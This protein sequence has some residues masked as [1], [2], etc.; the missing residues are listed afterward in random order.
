[1]LLR[2]DELIEQHLYLV[3]PIAQRV[4][5]KVPPSFERDDLMQ[6]GYLGLLRAATRYRPREYNNTPFTAYA[7]PRIRG[8]ILDGIRR[9]SWR[10]GTHDSLDALL[11]PAGSSTQGRRTCSREPGVDCPIEINLDAQRLEERVA[12]AIARLS[13]L[14]A[15]I[16]NLYY[17]PGLP[18]LAEVAQ[19]LQLP[20]SRVARE[21]AA[22]IAELRAALGA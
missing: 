10:E 13:P 17:C 12:Q 15:A 19:R 1:M 2:R 11:G 18:S 9:K 8:E 14:R 6:L 16:L 3:A 7:R 4:L 20:V 5:R 21:R 22:A